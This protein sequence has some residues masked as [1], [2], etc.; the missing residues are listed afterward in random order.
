MSPHQPLA[1]GADP[2]DAMVIK[3][4]VH[5][6]IRLSPVVEDLIQTVEVQRLNFIHQLGMTFHVYPGAHHAFANPSGTRYDAEAAEQ[7]WQRT[8]SFLDR[9]L[10]AEAAPGTSP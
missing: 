3:D 4:P 8:L 9:T 2:A 10:R 1:R 5:G 6:Q 7:A